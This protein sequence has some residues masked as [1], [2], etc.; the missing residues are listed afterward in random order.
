M[1]THYTLDFSE[2]LELTVQVDYSLKLML[3][4]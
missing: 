2:L 4:I 1:K 3:L